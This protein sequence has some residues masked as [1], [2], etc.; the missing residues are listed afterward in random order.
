MDE[1]GLLRVGLVAREAERHAHARPPLRA[2]DA[3]GPDQGHAHDGDAGGLLRAVGPRRRRRRAAQ[4]NMFNP[5]VL[6]NPGQ[7]PTYM[8]YTPDT[9]GY[10][11][12][13][14]NFAPSRRHDVAAERRRRGFWRKILGDPEQAVVSAGFT[15]AFNRERIDRFTDVF[16][17]NP[18]STVPATREHRRD[19]FPLVPAGRDLAAALHARTN[20]L[21]PPDFQK[22]PTFPIVARDQQRHRDLRSG[23]P[24]RRT[25]IR[26]RSAS[27]ARSSRD[28]AVEVR[29]I[30]N[31]NKKPWDD[32]NWNDANIVENGLIDEFKMAQA[33]LLANVAGRPRR[34]VRLLRPGHRTPRRSRSSWRTSPVSRRRPATRPTTRRPRSPTTRSSPTALGRRNLDPLFPDPRRHRRRPVGRATAACGARTAAPPATRRT[35]GS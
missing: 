22:T 33:N 8:P 15:R 18:G 29:Y 9:P 3:D 1:F 19:E 13:K 31:R 35:S 27:S 7:I 17:G 32:E 14:N 26:G 25:R 10:N 11:I 30:G 21:G 34:D 20:R 28:T 2:P 23:H 5:G 12:D 4:C 24:D 16:G 6:N